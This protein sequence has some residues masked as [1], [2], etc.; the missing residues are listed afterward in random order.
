MC[1]NKIIIQKVVIYL[2]HTFFKTLKGV[3]SM[4]KNKNKGV[5]TPSTTSYKPLTLNSPVKPVIPT[6]EKGV[7]I[8][9]KDLINLDNLYDLVAKATKQMRDGDNIS[10]CTV[11]KISVQADDLDKEIYEI[12]KLVGAIPATLKYQDILA[13]QKQ[14]LEDRVLDY[15]KDLATELDKLTLDLAG[16]FEF[17][18]AVDNHIYLFYQEFNLPYSLEV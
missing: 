12:A 17:D 8:S 6:L 14:T 9:V 2:L 18:F 1:Y 16:H 3:L 10:Y 5:A 13:S 11:V 15:L 7:K 4:S